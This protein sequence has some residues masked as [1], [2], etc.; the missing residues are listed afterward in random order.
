VW[1][2]ALTWVAS[3]VEEAGSSLRELGVVHWAGLDKKEPDN[4]TSNLHKIPETPQ[5]S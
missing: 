2:R 3:R 5:W 4:N 1:L